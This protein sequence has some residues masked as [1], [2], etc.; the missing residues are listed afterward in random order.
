MSYLFLVTV[1]RIVFDRGH[2]DMSDSTRQKQRHCR[3]KALNSGT[4]EIG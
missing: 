2:V 1:Y 4:K 3:N